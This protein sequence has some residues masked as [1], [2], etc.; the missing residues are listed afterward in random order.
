VSTINTPSA[1]SD[2]PLFERAHA[3]RRQGDRLAALEAAAAINPEHAGVRAETALELARLAG[4][5]RQRQTAE[6]LSRLSRSMPLR[7]AELGHIARQRGDRAAALAAFEAAIIA[8]PNHAGF[9][10]QAAFD[11]RVLGRIEEAKNL[12]VRALE[13]DIKNVGA[14]AELGHIARHLG[15]HSTALAA[16]KRGLELQPDHTGLKHR[17]RPNCESSDA[18]M[19][20][21][22]FARRLLLDRQAEQIG[23]AHNG[24]VVEKARLVFQDLML[25]GHETQD[26]FAIRSDP[27]G[28]ESQRRLEALRHNMAA[29]RGSQMLRTI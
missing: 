8:H 19:K 10:V 16:F 22:R 28:G 7:W 17:L 24:E 3:A 25:G 21:R 5:T 2:K 20:R 27:I 15:D 13:I 12:C 14:F 26:A 11:S 6:R 18:T 4:C 9:K 29:S 1:N 23:E